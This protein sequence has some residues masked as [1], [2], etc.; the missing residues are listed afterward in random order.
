MFWSVVEHDRPAES[1]GQSEQ[2][3]KLS[4]QLISEYVR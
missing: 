2:E 3:N 1:L 4:K